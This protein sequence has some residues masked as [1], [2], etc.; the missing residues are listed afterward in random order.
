MMRTYA[1]ESLPPVGRFH[2]HQGV[3]LTGM[4]EIYRLTGNEALLRYIKAW[5]DSLVNEFGDIL[6]FNPGQL[7]DLEPGV[8]LFPLYEA[9]GDARYK[10]AMDTIFWFYEHFPTNSRGGFWHNAMGRDQMWLDGLYM[11]G[12]FIAQYAKAFGRPEMMDVIVLQA[13][14]MQKLTRDPK[15]GLWYH[16]VDTRKRHAWA[17]KDTGCSPEFWGRAMGW[18]P[19]A[20]LNEMDYLDGEHRSALAHITRDLLEALIPYQDEATGLWY[21]VVDKGGQPGNWL[22]TSCTCLYAAG[23]CKAVRAGVLP[24]ETL[25]TAKKAIRGVISRLEYNGDDVLIKDI[26]EGTWIGDYDFYI[27]RKRCTNDL[28]GVG[29]FLILCAEAERVFDNK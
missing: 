27:H 17:N 8:L 28:H 16:A 25:Q 15:T 18:V 4:H 26:C 1:P 20:L 9:T 22:E 29:A 14:L 7:D 24:K 13:E 5:V 12:P 11:A 21:Q 3:F 2:Y 10:Q 23:I 19:M 6:N